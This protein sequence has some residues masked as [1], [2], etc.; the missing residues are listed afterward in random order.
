MSWNACNK[1]LDK[2]LLVLVKD[3]KKVQLQNEGF[4]P[5]VNQLYYRVSLMPSG[6]T[7][8]TCADAFISMHGIYQ[9]TVVAP[10]TGGSEPGLS[11]VDAL[12]AHF[13]RKKLQNQGI[14]LICSTPVPGPALRENAQDNVWWQ[15]PVTIRFQ[16]LGG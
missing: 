6:T 13:D 1:A 15:I 11:A 9:I 16:T 7:P 4:T 8:A 5:V 12:V 3:K 10:G 2:H 14:T